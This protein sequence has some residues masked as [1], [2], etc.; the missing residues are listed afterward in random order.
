MSK[1]E[2]E[3]LA[4]SHEVDKIASKCHISGNDSNKLLEFHGLISA[5]DRGLLSSLKGK[6]S[7]D[8]CS[9]LSDLTA[10]LT[11]LGMD[12][13][14]L[15]YGYRDVSELFIRSGNR[16]AGL[17][18]NSFNQERFR[19][20]AG[21]VHRMAIDSNSFDSITSYYG[22]FGTIDDSLDLAT[23]A[24]NESIRVVKPG[25]VISIGPYKSAAI[26]KLQAQN[27]E[28]IINKLQQRDDISVFV[29]N[30]YKQAV[31]SSSQDISRVGRVIIEKL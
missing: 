15:D 24:I 31:F 1:Q 25:G 30:P 5:K 3:S 2:L 22:I 11:R 19:Y 6:K 20:I 10:A 8:V 7:L 14:A 26:T 12:A 13:Y 16:P 9:G 4:I 29:K 28:K 21:S 18:L 17:F 23:M 27:E